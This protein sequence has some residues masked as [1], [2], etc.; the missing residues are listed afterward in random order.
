MFDSLANS[1]DNGVP[2]EDA[3]HIGTVVF[4][5]DPDMLQRIRAT[6]PGFL[7]GEN[8][9]NLPWIGP[10]HP[11][12]FG[13]NKGYGVVRVPVV[14]SMVVI[15]FQGG[16]I[17]HGM[18]VGYVPTSAFAKSMPEAL[19]TNYPNRVGYIDPMGTVV[20]TDVSTGE[21][22]INHFAGSTMTLEPSGTMLKIHSNINLDGVTLDIKETAITVVAETVNV[23]GNT[24]VK[25]SSPVSINMDTPTVNA[26]S[27]LK[28]G[29]GASGTL[30]DVN[31][32]VATFQKGICTQIS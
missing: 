17:H 25:V 13:M 31:G 2:I 3:Y 4:N 21:M 5:K 24:S 20:Y 29:N 22:T 9:D 18:Y 30:V 19:K 7:D 6:V 15:K 16:D 28:V 14:G 32:K 10:N 1:E 8:I 23:T 12:A 27:A 26:S 11:S